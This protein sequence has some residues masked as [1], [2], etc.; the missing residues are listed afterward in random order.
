L[1]LAS[2]RGQV[3]DQQFVTA[4]PE[5]KE[6]NLNPVTG[7]RGVVRVTV[8]EPK[9]GRLLPMAERLVF[10]APA[11]RMALSFNKEGT[12]TATALQKREYVQLGIRGTTETG[13]PAKGWILAAV[14]DDQ[15]VSGTDKKGEAGPPAFFHLT[16]DVPQ[17]AALEDANF[18]VSDVPGAQ[19]SLDLFLGTFGWRRFVSAEGSTVLAAG[20]SKETA[21][22]RTADIPAV[23]QAS[24]NPALKNRYGAALAQQADQLRTQLRNR[25]DA[26][27]QDREQ[28]ATEAAR[29]ASALAE[30][31][32]LPR[33]YLRLGLGVLSLVLLGVGALALL[34]GLARSLRRSGSPTACFATAFGALG[35]C[36]VMYAMTGSLRVEAG[37]I[38]SGR[39]LAWLQAGRNYLD[40]ENAGGRELQREI[41]PESKDSGFPDGVFVGRIP[42]DKV[43]GSGGQKDGSAAERLHEA[44]IVDLVRQRNRQANA[45]QL[46]GRLDDLGEME[47]KK[48]LLEKGAEARPG[49]QP[50]GAFPGGVGSSPR[51]PAAPDAR[52]DRHGDKAKGGASPPSSLTGRR[53]QVLRSYARETFSADPD[54]QETILWQPGLTLQN[55]HAQVGFTVSD[56]VT[57]YRVFLYGHTPSG[58]LGF[59]HGTLEVRPGR[60]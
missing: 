20:E 6:V 17:A 4:G 43:A 45:A 24:N 23:F 50:P 15:V 10:H 25:R 5:G 16:N 18:L 47:S 52:A 60:K 51:P 41:L 38:D 46:A 55:G 59:A 32:Q 14:V 42:Q 12:P 11:E 13:K 37:R 21:T 33:D 40:V 49:T 27:L 44:G 3:V 2:C 8:Y 22:N 30:F 1:V 9:D 53:E 58:S 56:R 31:E 28:H 26:L 29:A 35:L 36:L 57:T 39:D 19:Q 48:A 54:R 34:M 7:T